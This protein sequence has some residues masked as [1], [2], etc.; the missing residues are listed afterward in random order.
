MTASRHPTDGNTK[1]RPRCRH[2]AVF[3]SR[4]QRLTW[5]WPARDAEMD[6]RLFDTNEREGDEIAV[7]II[8]NF[9]EASDAEIRETKSRPRGDD[10]SSG[11]AQR[12]E[13]AVRGD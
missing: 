8:Q 11:I 2:M 12:D 9:W 13:Y 4:Y 6:E 10:V 5:R 7:G 3:R 1:P